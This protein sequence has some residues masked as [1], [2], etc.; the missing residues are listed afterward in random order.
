MESTEDKQFKQN[1]RSSAL[2]LIDKLNTEIATLERCISSD[3]VK[4]DNWVYTSFC[5]EKQIK[6]ESVDRLKK[7]IVED[8][9]EY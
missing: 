5:L 8:N 9:F 6:L 7:M 1:E 3:D 4:V 2:H